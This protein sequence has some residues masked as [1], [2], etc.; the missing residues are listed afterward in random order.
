MYAG[1]VTLQ[2]RPETLD[3]GAST[4]QA[5]AENHLKQQKGYQ[6]GYFLA[7]RTTGKALVFALWETEADA[8]GYE[9]QGQYPD[10]IAAFSNLLTEK[11]TRVIYE[12]GA[13]VS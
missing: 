5:I 7:D 3:I 4:W 10:L 11:P 1:V 8:V 13:Q 12:V 6:S 2:M 9:T